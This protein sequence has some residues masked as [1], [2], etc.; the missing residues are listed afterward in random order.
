MSG[1][2]KQI[3]K[4]KMVAGNDA[5][6]DPIENWCTQDKDDGHSVF[7]FIRQESVS[8][9]LRGLTVRFILICNVRNV[10]TFLDSSSNCECPIFDK[11]YSRI[12][13]F[14]VIVYMM[15]MFTCAIQGRMRLFA[16]LQ[17]QAIKLPCG[18]E[19]RT[20]HSKGL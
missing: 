18:T 11:C 19:A 15:F 2:A 8:V 20:V 6:G 17:S 3:F 16:I 4:Y 1:R 5:N 9:H 7:C 10:F 12:S 13:I 14:I